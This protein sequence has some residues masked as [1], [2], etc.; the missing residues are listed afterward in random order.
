MFR[1]HP[2]LHGMS[3]D[4]F[5][6]FFSSRRRHT[7]SKRDWSSDVCSSDL[8]M[9]ILGE[10]DTNPD[11]HDVSSIRCMIVGG[12]A[13]PQAMIEAF[14]KRHGLRITHAWGMTET[15]PLGSVSDPTSRDRKSVV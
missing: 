9:G 1:L 8:W 10:L 14:E 7:R 13:A 15:C 11:Q 4:G 2:G 5:L 12:S 3:G 6:F